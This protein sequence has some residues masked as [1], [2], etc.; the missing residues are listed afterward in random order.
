MKYKNRMLAQLPSYERDNEILNDIYAAFGDKT[1]KFLYE[2]EDL[3]KQLNIDT[4]TWGLNVWERNVGLDNNKE[5]SL[6]QRRG[7][8][9]TRLKGFGKI[10]AELLESTLQN[11]YDNKVDVFFD[12]RVLLNIPLEGDSWQHR[13]VIREIIKILKP[14]H[15]GYSINMYTKPVETSLF[16]GSHTTMGETLTIYP[17]TIQDI[18][19]STQLYAGLAYESIYEDITLIG[20][21]EG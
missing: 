11:Y 18:E 7:R 21:K 4:A 5:L 20:T 9:K 17:K 14:A 2:I 3:Y 8:V 1:D 19:L 10:D 16:L 13:Q 15:L 6:V 12:G